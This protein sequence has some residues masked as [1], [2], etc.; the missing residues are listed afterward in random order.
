MENIIIAVILVY[1]ISS[2]IFYLYRA[3]K[4]GQIC[5]GCSCSKQCAGEKAG[6]HGACCNCD[7]SALNKARK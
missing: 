3:K 4:N 7:D 1:I 6:N 5:V 2:V